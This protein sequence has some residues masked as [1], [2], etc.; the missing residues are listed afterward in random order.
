MEVEKF[1]DEI[2]LGKLTPI[3]KT[4]SDELRENYRPV[5]T[6]GK[7]FEKIIYSRLYNYFVS[8]G[9]LHDKQFGFR[10]YHSTSYALN[11]SIDKI[12][13]II[14]KGDHVLGIFIDLRGP[15]IIFYAIIV[16]GKQSYQI[17]FTRSKNIDL[18]RIDHIF[19]IA[20]YIQLPCGCTL[21]S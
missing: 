6:F 4:N 14:E 9:I 1:P 2:K 8:K 5:S 12:K 16:D 3:Y 10:K 19:K 13:Q 7:I 18:S 11:Y 21:Y 15:K 17:L 20:K